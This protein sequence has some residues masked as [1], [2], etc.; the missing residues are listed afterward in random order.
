MQPEETPGGLDMEEY[1]RWWAAVQEAQTLLGKQN[2][3]PP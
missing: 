3:S 1:Q 2:R